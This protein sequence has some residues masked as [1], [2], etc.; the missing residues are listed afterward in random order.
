MRSS[1]IKTYEEHERHLRLVLET[2]RKIKF[3]AKL[4]K[5]EFWFLEVAFQGHV[6]N[7]PGIL[8][9]PSKVSTIIDWPRPSKVQEVRSSLGLVG[10]YRKF[11]NEFSIITTP[12]TKLTQKDVTDDC[13]NIFS[14]LKNSVF[15]FLLFPS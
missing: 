14:T 2:L 3:Y 8:V 12:T 11:V 13:E 7:Q 1:Y 15:L 4:E 10:Y 5:Y 9:D 6:I